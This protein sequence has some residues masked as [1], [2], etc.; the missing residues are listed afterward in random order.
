MFPRV[1]LSE[2]C[3]KRGLHSFFI[4]KARIGR[5]LSIGLLSPPAPGTTYVKCQP[6]FSHDEFQEAQGNFEPF[7]IVWDKRAR[8]PAGSYRNVWG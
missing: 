4:F 3:P 8:Y 7:R 5:G 6:S 1:V 2:R